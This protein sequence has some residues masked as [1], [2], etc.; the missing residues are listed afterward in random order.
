MRTCRDESDKNLYMLT[1]QLK[2]A[3]GTIDELK[4]VFDAKVS[5]CK[6]LEIEVET[7][8]KEC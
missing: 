7:K 2:E 4:L 8:D 3:K 6:E 1:T 5:R